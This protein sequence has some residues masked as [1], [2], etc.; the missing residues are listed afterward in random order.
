MPRCRRWR[1]ICDRLSNARSPGVSDKTLHLAT[2]VTPDVDP[3]SRRIFLATVNAVVAQKNGNILR[4][5][6]Q[7]TMSSGAEMVLQT[8]RSW[9]L[10]VWQL[11]GPPSGWQTQLERF[12]ADKPV[13]ALASGL[14]AGNWDPVQCFC[15]QQSVPC[16]F[17][18]VAA[19]PVQQ[20]F[21]SVYFSRGAALEADV[22]ASQLAASKRPGRVLQVYAEAGVANS[23]VA[24]LRVK[25]AEAAIE[26][27][28][29]RLTDDAAALA[30]ELSALGQQDSVVF[31]LAPSQLKLLEQLPSPQ[32]MSFSQR[33]WAAATG[34]H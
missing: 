11:Q 1:A 9:D 24:A 33:L 19:V 27:S 18:T 3:E 21:Y 22:L 12:Q 4:N 13:F 7:R 30:R 29:Y 25:L 6:G 5:A 23:A 20:G 28:Q 32:A 15:E 34:C 26:S 10:Q 14:G 2:V 31:W 17:P 8:D 16:C